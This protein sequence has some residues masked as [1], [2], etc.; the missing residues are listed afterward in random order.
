MN[1]RIPEKL[2]LQCILHTK[3]REC[4]LQICQLYPR[5]LFNI[6]ACGAFCCAEGYHYPRPI[7]SRVSHGNPQWRAVKTSIW[8]VLATEWRSGVCCC[9]ISLN[10]CDAWLCTLK[11]TISTISLY[12]DREEGRGE[13]EK[14][15]EVQQSRRRIYSERVLQEAATRH[16]YTNEM[17]VIRLEP[18][19]SQDGR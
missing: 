15:V 10:D 18:T 9:C 2:E 5:C 14:S 6:T 16:Q 1:T 19:E 3:N 8:R 4:H 7:L 13:K 11:W 12:N 17:L